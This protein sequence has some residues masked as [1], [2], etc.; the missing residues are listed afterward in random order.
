MAP[1]RVKL[2]QRHLQLHRLKEHHQQQRLRQR[3]LLRLP[4]QELLLVW[5]QQLLPSQLLQLL[6]VV[7]LHRVLLQ[8]L[9]RQVQLAYLLRQQKR[10]QH[11][12]QQP[13]LQHLLVLLE[14]PLLQQRLQQQP[15]EDQ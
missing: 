14:E 15:V 7:V 2:L 3:L 12:H 9:Q 11:Q 8:P 5:H 4:V 13:R 10:Q 1:L 6:Q